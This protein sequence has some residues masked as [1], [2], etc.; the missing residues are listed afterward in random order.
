MHFLAAQLFGYSFAK[1]RDKLEVKAERFT[2]LM[3]EDDVLAAVI[4]GEYHGSRLSNDSTNKIVHSQ[5]A[6]AEGGFEIF[7]AP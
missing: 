5:L 7:W 6:F 2:D 4:R 3:P 1:Y